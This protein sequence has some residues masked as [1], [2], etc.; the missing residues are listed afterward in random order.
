MPFPSGQFDLIV[1]TFSLHHWN[2]PVQVLNEIFRVLKPGGIFL[3]T[4]LSRNTPVLFINLILFINRMTM[5][6]EARDWFKNS[7]HG[8]IGS[9]KASYTQ[10]ELTGIMAQTPFRDYQI[11]EDRMVITIKGSKVTDQPETGI[12]KPNI[13][14]IDGHHATLEGD[15]ARRYDWLS[16]TYMKRDFKNL[17]QKIQELG[18]ETHNILD[19]GCGSGLLLTEIFA[20]M[21]RMRLFGLDTSKTMIEIANQR[22][23]AAGGVVKLWEEARFPYDDN[24]FDIVVSNWALH[25]WC[26]PNRVF[27]ELTRVLK[28]GGLLFMID[29]LRDASGEE[30]E[31]LTD[32]APDFLKEKVR[33]L[34]DN[35]TEDEI[36]KKLPENFA[37][38]KRWREKG[39]L[40]IIMSRIESP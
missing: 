1:S 9:I 3:I 14:V 21:P 33:E 31:Q 5:T 7:P 26:F 37:I 30:L 38:T 16:T 40:F 28:T 2:D 11:N 20:L 6:K 12:P 17:A 36:L 25:H 18:L 32:G 34:H 24:F 4:D 35:Y 22:L 8:F 27:T 29:I 23:Q 39:Q 10:K 19:L 15:A 13:N